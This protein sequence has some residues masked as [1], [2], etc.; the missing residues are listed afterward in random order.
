MLLR[1]KTFIPRI[2]FDHLPFLH[3]EHIF[4]VTHDALEIL[5]RKE[6][7]EKKKEKKKEWKSM[8]EAYGLT[9]M[10]PQTR[11]DEAAGVPERTRK[12]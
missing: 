3:N 6:R 11:R 12:K 4:K 10:E 2:I 8:Q 1:L 9:K 7:E 5:L